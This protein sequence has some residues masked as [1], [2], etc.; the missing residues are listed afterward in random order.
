MRISELGGHW[1]P[2]GRTLMSAGQS[3]DV[4]TAEPRA[5][6]PR[7]LLVEDDPGYRRLVREMLGQGA[8]AG[9]DVVQAGG[10]AEARARLDDPLIDCALVD[11]SL[12]DASGVEA[13]VGLLDRAPDLA[14][15]VLTG[16]TDDGTGLA[17]VRA[18]AQDYLCKGAVDPSVLAR[19]VRFALERKHASGGRDLLT[20]LPGRQALATAAA[21]AVL[22]VGLDNF[23]AVNESLGHDTADAVLVE[24]AARLRSILGPGD[25]LARLG[26]DV[27]A[28]SRPQATGRVEAEAMSSLVASTVAAPIDAGGQGVLVSASVGVAV[29]GTDDVAA[30]ALLADAES[31]LRRAK[32]RGR[33]RVEVHDDRLRAE[34]RER[35]R[36]ESGLGRAVADGRLRLVYQS[37]VSLTTDATAAVEALVRWEDPEHGTVA[38]ARFIPIAEASGSILGIG[39]WVLQEACRQAVRLNRVPVSVNLSARQMADRRLV[40]LVA[41]TLAATGLPPGRLCL[42][43][44]ERSLVED[45]DASITTLRALDELGVTLAVD[46]FGTGSSGFAYL[47]RF[48]F[49]LLKID[50][51]FVAGLGA[52][53][54]GDSVVTAMIALAHSFDMKVVGEGVERPSQLSRLRQLGCDYAQGFHISSPGPQPDVREGQ[55]PGRRLGISFA[56]RSGSVVLRLVGELDADTAPAL[57]HGLTDLVDEQGNLSVVLDLGAVAR[58]APEGADVLRMT[59]ERLSAKGGSLTLADPS[60]L[61]ARSLVNSGLGTF[62]RPARADPLT[63]SHAGRIQVTVTEAP[64]EGCS[65]QPSAGLPGSANATAQPPNPPPVILAP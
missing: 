11:L 58:I 3:P 46:D 61:V 24:V 49:D 51:A 13:V 19:S 6:S 57:R 17:A 20:G 35:A 60:P 9:S 44:N 25:L 5:A 55:V 2:V 7:I 31:A 26:G 22:A 43:V 14:L 32:Q 21:G 8:M 62:L 37:I 39:E 10:L 53:P 42:E 1:V 12:P 33:G 23:T 28:V 29:A 56:R 65:R 59:A 40:P 54:D 45:P 63:R 34:A 52:S 30:G 15:V 38:A 48:P 4:K 16:R 18:G 64:P 41:E 36:I 27:F 50:R 47:R